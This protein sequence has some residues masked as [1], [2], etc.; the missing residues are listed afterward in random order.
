MNIGGIFGPKLSGKTT[1]ARSISREYWRVHHI[2]TLV[3]DPNQDMDFGPQ[4]L[5]TPDEEKFWGMVWKS[6][7]CLIV[8]EEAA[9]TI[10]RERD[11]VPVFTRI[12]HQHHKLLVVGHSGTDLLPVMRQ[13]VDV[14][15]LF[16]QNEESALIWSKTFCD[17]RLIEATKLGQYEF[18]RLEMFGEPQKMRLANGA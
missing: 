2:R 7:D 18:I 13:Q 6:R 9:A 5:N 14:I 16:R 1:L 15:Y 8:V 17:V 11:L 12:R 4:A 10:R 3:L